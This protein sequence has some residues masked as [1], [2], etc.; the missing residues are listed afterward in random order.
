MCSISC[1]VRNHLYNQY[2]AYIHNNIYNIYVQRLDKSNNS[3]LPLQ[4]ENIYNP[5]EKNPTDPSLLNGI[6]NLM[7]IDGRPYFFSGENRSKRK[8]YLCSK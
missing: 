3:K 6:F 2:N 1:V 4:C 5:F 8:L 7:V